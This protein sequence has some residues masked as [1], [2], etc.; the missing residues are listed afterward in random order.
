MDT[1]Q[2]N[3]QETTLTTTEEA[4]KELVLAVLDDLKAR[5]VLH[6]NVRGQ[7]DFA[8]DMFIATGT[9]SRHVSAIVDNLVY[10]LKQESHPIIGVEG[11]RQNHWVLID[12]GDMVL[13]IM[14]EEAR[15]F[16]ALEELWSTEYD[17]SVEANPS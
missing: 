11:D 15:K 16:Y 17:L 13:H 4:T 12:L 7:A 5:D 10:R 8:D 9:S 3:S 14:R 1:T 2:F 6:L